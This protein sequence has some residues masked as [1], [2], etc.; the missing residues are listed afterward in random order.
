VAKIEIWKLTK[1]HEDKNEK[2]EKQYKE[3]VAFS[4]CIGHGVGTIDF[5]EKVAVF[6]EAEWAEF[7]SGAGAWTMGK[8]GNIHRYFEIE[9]SVPQAAFAVG[10]LACESPL[11]EILANLKEGYLTIR[12]V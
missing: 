9:V 6:D 7:L 11:K 1:R 3:I 5:S 10:E 2:L 4:T 12:K 8:F